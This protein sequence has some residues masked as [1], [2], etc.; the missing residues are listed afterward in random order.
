MARALEVLEC[1]VGWIWER[2]L[3]GRAPLPDP[4]LLRTHPATREERT[5][6]LRELQPYDAHRFHVVN[7]PLPPGGYPHIV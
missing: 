1:T 6:R 3:P 2:L 4:L 5:R 7:R